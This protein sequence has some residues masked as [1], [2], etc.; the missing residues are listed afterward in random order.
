MASRVKR[1]LLV[2]RGERPGDLEAAL[3][4]EDEAQLAG[5]TQA[6]RMGRPE[7]ARRAP[8]RPPRTAGSDGRSS[9]R[10]S[11]SRR[12][13][14][15]LPYLSS[16]PISQS[17]TGSKA[18][19]KA[20]STPLCKAHSR[21]SRVFS[22]HGKNRQN[23]GT[24]RER[25]G[26]ARNFRSFG[27][28][29]D[30][31]P[32]D[33]TPDASSSRRARSPTTSATALARM[34][35]EALGYIEG[36]AGDEVTLA[37]NVAAWRR[38]ALRP[39]MLVGASGCDP[40]VTV[41]GVR[42]PHPVIVAPTAFQRLAHPDGELG[43]RPSGGGDRHRDVRVDVR[44]RR[45]GDG[46][47]GRPRGGALVPA[48][49]PHRP[50]RHPRAH[51]RRGP[52]RLRG[53][54]GDRRPAGARHPRARVAGEPARPGGRHPAPRPRADARRPGGGALRADRPGPALV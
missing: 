3:L 13:P 28:A 1:D 26:T 29:M 25:Q 6:V 40:S 14:D 52:S 41:L 8:C 5:G 4:A 16:T 46:R 51:R 48:L 2:G 44:Q 36:G 38:W 53:A 23:A 11:P 37:D 45:R 27:V 50:R 18:G 17:H 15:H 21:K 10:S 22:H 24:L 47:R 30:A 49:R 32:D 33:A 7:R 43:D 34:S 42:R 19:I 39:R 54:G 35:P 20:D 31:A 12:A 9:S